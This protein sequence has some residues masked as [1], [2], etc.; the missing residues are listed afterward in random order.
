MKRKVK[1]MHITHPMQKV[2][3]DILNDLEIILM[4]SNELDTREKIFDEILN[5]LHQQSKKYCLCKDPFTYMLCTGKEYEENS[6]EYQ[7]QLAIEK[8]GHC[9]WLE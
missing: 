7:K 1:Q 3:V 5:I 8:Y 2:A 4:Q 9:D 6:L